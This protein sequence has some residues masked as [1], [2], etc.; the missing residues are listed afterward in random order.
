MCFDP[1][2]IFSQVAQHKVLEQRKEEKA[3]GFFEDDKELNANDKPKDEKS[4]NKPRFVK[5]V[6]SVILAS[7]TLKPF[8]VLEQQLETE[9][10]IKLEN[11]HIISPSQLLFSVIDKGIDGNHLDF[12]FKNRN[13]TKML[14]DWGHT[15]LNIIKQI[16]G[17][18]LLFFPSYDLKQ[19]LIDEWKKKKLNIQGV[20]QSIYEL[21]EI[22]I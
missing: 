7:G 17:G 16:K 22:F 15:I 2:I 8:Q 19:K 14:H 4:L 12:T 18:V 6:I 21:I 9:F 10:P 20:K 3:N 11:D 5:S 1:S 13:N